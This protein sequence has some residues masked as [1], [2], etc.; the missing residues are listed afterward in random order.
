MLTVL[1]SGFIRTIILGYIVLLG[2]WL[3]IYAT[4]STDAQPSYIFGTIYPFL[5]IAGG[6]AALTYSKRW[7]GWKSVMGKGIIFLGLGLFGE[8]FGQLVWSYYNLILQDI[9]PYPSI[10]DIGYFSIIPFYAIAMLKFARASGA[11]FSLQD[12]LNKI[13]VVIIPIVML[14]LSYVFFLRD[15][16]LD[17]SAPIKTF[18]DFGYPMGEAIMISIAILTFT[19]SR[20]FLGGVMK[21]KIL[22]II[23][24]FVV[25]YITDYTFLYKVNAETYVNGGIVDL[26]YATSFAIMAIGIAMIG[27]NSMSGNEEKAL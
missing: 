18:L 22:Y 12:Y 27:E 23:F 20:K 11:R 16:E 25:Q 26:M 1:R 15:Y 10:A 14:V 8:A 4:G 13:Q 3:W 7:G 24:A 9:A 6:I 2:F 21:A 19:L 17:L 5:A